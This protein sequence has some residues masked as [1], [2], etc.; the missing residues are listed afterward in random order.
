MIGN[1]MFRLF[2]CVPLF[3]Y[4]TIGH[5]TYQCR[6]NSTCFQIFFVNM[7]SNAPT[8]LVVYLSMPNFKAFCVTQILIDVHVFFCFYQ[9]IFEFIIKKQK[10]SNYI[11]LINVH[12]LPVPSTKK[13]LNLKK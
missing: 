13:G 11:Y 1:L 7:L 6:S 3:H 12:F 10:S 2:Q 8:T 9:Y 5:H 4:L